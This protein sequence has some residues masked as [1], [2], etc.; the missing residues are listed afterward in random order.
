MNICFVITELGGG[1][2][3][4]VVS[5]LSNFF[6]KEGHLVDVICTTFKAN[7]SYKV[8]KSVRIHFISEIKKLS[9][10][11]KVK[12]IRN[13][14]VNEKPD[15]V[16][17]FFPSS[18]ILALIARI[19][20]KIKIVFSER[21]SP[22]DTPHKKIER[23]IRFIA[24]KLSDGL[25]FQSE[26]AA[27]YFERSIFRKK[28]V[29]IIGNPI[30]FDNLPMANFRYKRIIA[31][32][33]LFEQKNY[34]CLL[35]AFS[36]F[37]SDVPDYKLVIFGNG[38]ELGK[39][40]KLSIHL[41]ISNFVDFISFSN[42]IWQEVADSSIFVMSSLY[43]G[44]PN[45]LIEAEGIGLPVVVTDFRPGVAKELVVPGLN[46]EIVDNGNYRDFARALKLVS[47]NIKTYIDGAAAYRS[48]LEKR[49]D[50]TFVSTEWLGFF[51]IL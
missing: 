35:R 36:I 13:I 23:F 45:S 21:N 25:V 33:R 48:N 17:T 51:E 40:K 30:D 24:I 18:F 12:A 8:S 26:A 10:A 11:K 43:E 32:S 44:L 3:E 39:L 37:R 14:F 27:R 50:A 5:V 7:K 31:T 2:S 15:V 28:A 29:K 47:E 9:F 4:R 20:L 16:I 41:G 42:D 1:G 6:A 34:P 22:K 38:P 49:F 19:G 46:G